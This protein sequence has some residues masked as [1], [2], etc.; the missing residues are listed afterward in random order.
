MVDSHW[1]QCRCRSP[2]YYGVAGID[3]RYD[4]RPRAPPPGARSRAVALATIPRN[5]RVR[6]AVPL[7]RRS[8]GASDGGPRRSARRRARGQR[9]RI[10]HMQRM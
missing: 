5:E 10:Q 6:T 9:I 3:V 1:R 2:G 4:T 7:A 8:E